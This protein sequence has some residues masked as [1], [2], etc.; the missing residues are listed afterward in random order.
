[1]KLVESDSTVSYISHDAKMR[2]VVVWIDV[3]DPDKY[4]WYYVR[5][6]EGF[7]PLDRL[8][9]LIRNADGN[10]AFAKLPKPEPE[11]KPQGPKTLQEARE[12]EREKAIAAITARNTHR[13]AENTTELSSRNQAFA[14]AARRQR[15]ATTSAE[16][17]RKKLPVT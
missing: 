9:G 12:F 7:S 13:M 2:T 10:P 5:T 15:I 8:N 16:T 17:D 6:E 4:P 3:D 1:M 11:Q 14:D